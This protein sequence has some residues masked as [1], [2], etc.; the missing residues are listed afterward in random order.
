[1]KVFKAPH[2]V[3]IIGSLFQSSVAT[4]CACCLPKDEIIRHLQKTAESSMLQ[5]KLLDSRAAL[6]EN[7]EFERFD[8]MIIGMPARMCL[9]SCVTIPNLG[10]FAT[11]N[12]CV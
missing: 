9:A 8:V 1:M 5:L 11:L 6:N 12:S 7:N 10:Y 4:T 3:S 2:F